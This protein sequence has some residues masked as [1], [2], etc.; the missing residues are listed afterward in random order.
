MS[1]IKRKSAVLAIL[2]ALGGCAAPPFPGVNQLTADIS[3]TPGIVIA[4]DHVDRQYRIDDS[5]II[6]VTPPPSLPRGWLMLDF[7]ETDG[8]VWHML[9]TYESGQPVTVGAP[10]GDAAWVLGEPPGSKM[11]LAVVSDK[12]LPRVEL[13]R[14][15]DDAKIYLPRLREQ[16]AAAKASGASVAVESLPLEVVAR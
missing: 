14:E 7:V 16:L 11:L 13:G 1:E 4:P 10:S 9:S 15:K 6:R 12:P 8:A 5:L 2:A 3:T